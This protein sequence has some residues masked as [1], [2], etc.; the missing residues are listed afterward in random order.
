VL[1]AHVVWPQPEEIPILARHGVGVAHCPQSNM[2]LASGVAP[3]L[4]LRGAGV[5]VGL[6]TDGPAS[7]NDLDMW[8]E[9]GSAA[10]L[11]KLSQNDPTAMDARAVLALATRDGARALH[12]EDRIGSLEPGKQADLVVVGLEGPH[13]QPVFE[14][15]SALV[16]ATKASDV[17]TVMVAGKVVVEGGRVLTVDAPAVLAKAAEYRDQIRTSLAP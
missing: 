16:Y 5:A 12:L 2:K 11:H 8:D 15:H 4:A 17:R 1:A 13:Q 10:R 3:V 14:V 9:M 6:G 7:N